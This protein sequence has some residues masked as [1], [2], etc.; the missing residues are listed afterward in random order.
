MEYF[1][2]SAT[3]DLWFLGRE[4]LVVAGTV[5]VAEDGNF[6]ILAG[7]DDSG[8]VGIEGGHDEDGLFGGHHTCREEHSLVACGKDLAEDAEGKNNLAVVGQSDPASEKDDDPVFDN[9]DW[10]WGKIA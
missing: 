7:P 9:E 5:A 1:E 3:D 6:E 4:L 10:P 8:S 2:V